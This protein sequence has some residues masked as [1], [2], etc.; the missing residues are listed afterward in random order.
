MRH[1]HAG[2][3]A[4]LGGVDRSVVVVVLN[5]LR[6]DTDQRRAG[7][8]ELIGAVGVRAI[9]LTLDLV[10]IDVPVLLRDEKDWFTRL[11]EVNCRRVGRQFTT[12]R[13]DTEGNHA[14]SLPKTMRSRLRA[15]RLCY[16]GGRNGRRLRVPSSGRSQWPIRAAQNSI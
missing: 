5:R 13:R 7:D 3:L 2:H 12:K 11:A 1:H 14:R 10:A 4:L 6:D 16:L 15:Y 9:R 8:E